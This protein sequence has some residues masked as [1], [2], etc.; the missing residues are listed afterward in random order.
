MSR[1]TIAILVI[2]ACALLLALSGP[3]SW[4]AAKNPDAEKPAAKKAGNAPPDAEPADEEVPAKKEVRKPVAKEQTEDQ[5]KVAAIRADM[6]KDV[7]KAIEAARTYVKDGLDED[8]KTDATGVIADGLRKKGDWH[9]AQAAYLKARD[10]CEKGSEDYLRY[11]AIADL[12]K[13]SP[14]GIHVPPGGAK[15]GASK[16]D[17]KPLSDDAALEAALAHITQV[18]LEKLKGRMASLKRAK[19]PQEVVTLFT[20]IAD[21]YRQAAASMPAA[22]KASAEA[23][24][25]AGST[26][27]DLSVK[28]LEGL[29]NK[30]AQYQPKM[31]KPWSFNNVEQKDMGVGQAYCK[32]L[33]QSEQ[34]FQQ[35][36]GKMAGSGAAAEFQR[37]IRDS[38]VRKVNYERMAEGFVIPKW[39]DLRGW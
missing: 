18:K 38:D 24:A 15:A 12:L 23:A 17:A 11:D 31:D 21:D 29:R 33:A 10:R 4:A 34:R 36:V 1:F 14:T 26:L 27:Q 25:S 5:K 3:S 22:V 20:P 13:A 35:V 37:V 19:T 16:E 39:V 32:E 7:D 28:I 2:A 30:Q 6:D 9:G 8:A